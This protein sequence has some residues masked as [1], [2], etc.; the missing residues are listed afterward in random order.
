MSDRGT[1]I[2]GKRL[3]NDGRKSAVKTFDPRYGPSAEDHIDSCPDVPHES[4]PVSEGKI[5]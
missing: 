4:L 2:V 5:V 1:Q 3:G